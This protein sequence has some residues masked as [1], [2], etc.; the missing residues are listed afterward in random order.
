MVKG[1]IMSK[2]GKD[3]DSYPSLFD[4]FCLGDRVRRTYKDKKG[5]K[6]QEYRGTILAIANESI[7]IYWDTL[8]GKFRP[9]GMNVT[10]TECPVYE[11]FNGNE[12][13]S[14]IEK[15]GQ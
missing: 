9:T 7:E 2:N 8:N 10:F 1:D 13:Y 14:P 4:A 5:S 3:K 6:S 11:I 12:H 15:E